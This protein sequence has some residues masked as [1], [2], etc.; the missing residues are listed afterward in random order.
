MTS[1]ADTDAESKQ[2]IS[3]YE[4]NSSAFETT[5]GADIKSE[6]SQHEINSTSEMGQ[7]GEEHLNSK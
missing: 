6:Y 5:A 3:I 1:E 7:K 2:V 4:R